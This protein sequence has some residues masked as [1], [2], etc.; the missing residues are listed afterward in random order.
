[1]NGL[2][3]QEM[4][5]YTA[6]LTSFNS[7]KTIEQALNSI[8]HQEIPPFEVMVIDDNSLDSTVEITRSFQLKFGNLQ[9]VVN[10]KNKGQALNRNLA[11]RLSNTEFLIFFDDDDF[12][13]P[14]RSTL[15]ARHFE[16]DSDIS[17]VSSLKKYPKGFESKFIN[18][19]IT[20]YPS[21]NELVNLL[22]LGRKSD[23]ISK[24][25]IPSSTCAVSKAA[26]ISVDG[27]DESLRRLED[28]DLAI[29]FGLQRL[30]FSWSPDVGV[31]RSHTENMFKG[32]GID[33]VF[34]EILIQKYKDFMD[35]K[36]FRRA[37][38]HMQTRKLYFSRK[39]L[40]FMFHVL[41]NPIYSASSILRGKRFIK[42]LHHDLRKAI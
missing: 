41:K 31:V 18:N 14:V 30:K 28:I 42:R 26:L 34:E 38:I 35:Q 40:D 32:S 16:S 27:F 17:F 20:T 1:M 25:F 9:I 5:K 3:S 7:E 22:I 23:S 11:A 13:L 24:V 36:D 15:H 2:A 33:S 19:S 21:G 29:K 8:F 10:D 6:V 12:S 4:F 37:M 39:Y